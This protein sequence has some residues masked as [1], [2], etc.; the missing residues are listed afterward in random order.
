[1]GINRFFIESSLKKD[2]TVSIP[3]E[4]KKHFK[5]MRLQ[6]KDEIEL[7]NGKN[8]LAKGTITSIE[9]KKTL[10]LI[11]N[12]SEEKKPKQKLILYQAYVKPTKID[13]ILE[14]GCELGVD[15]FVFFKSKRAEKL[16][17]LKKQRHKA[18]LTSS[19]KQCGRLDLPLVVYTDTFNPSRDTCLYFGD[20]R[21]N[22]PFFPEYLYKNQTDKA[23]GFINGPESGFSDEEIK[24]FEAKFKAVGISL[25]KNVLR[26]ET[27]AICALSFCQIGVMIP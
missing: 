2:A 14:K 1:M 5:V 13:L 4:E 27:A 17:S 8:I 9:K 21:E 25:N 22:A 18:I 26:T 24:E 11:T 15:Q 19:I 12:V 16:F 3:E 20:L 23:I 6:E 7:I 10:V